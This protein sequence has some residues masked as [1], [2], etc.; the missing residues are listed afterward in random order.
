MN[1][2]KKKSTAEDIQVLQTRVVSALVFFSATPLLFDRSV[3]SRF[4]KFFYVKKKDT[5]KNGN[6]LYLTA[7]DDSKCAIVHY[8]F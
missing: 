4:L 7:A 5:F 6:S 2:R 8:I 1:K 3:R